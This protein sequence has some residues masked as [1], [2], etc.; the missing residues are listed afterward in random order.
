MAEENKNQVI[1]KGELKVVE[2]SNVK[3]S[4]E[5]P[6]K[7]EVKKEKKTDKKDAIQKKEEAIVRGKDLKISTKHSIAIC[8]FIKNHSPEKSSENLKKV[9]NKKI[10]IPMKGEIPHRKGIER[11]RYPINAC[12]QFTKLLKQ[13]SANS[14]INGLENPIIK[15]AKADRASRPYKRFGSMRFKRT[16]VLLIARENKVNKSKK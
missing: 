9:I 11:G 14:N 5:E 2:S 12:K 15:V 4:V 3:E 7:K 16:N 10:A 1:E 6:D 13:L 8:N